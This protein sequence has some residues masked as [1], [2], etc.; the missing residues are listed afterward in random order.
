MNKNNAF[1]FNV[2]LNVL[3]LF[4]ISVQFLFLG[5]DSFSLVF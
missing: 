3:M 2:I 5:F 4:Y 1:L